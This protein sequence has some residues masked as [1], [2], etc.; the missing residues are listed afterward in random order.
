MDSIDFQLLKYLMDNG[1]VTWKEINKKLGLSSPAIAER[2]R[3]LEENGII[4]GYSAILDSKQIGLDMTAFISVTLE[5]P[6]D[7]AP[8]LEKI[9]RIKE[10]LECHHIAGD[11]D[12]LLKVRCKNTNDLD[13]V[14]TYEIKGIKGVLKTNTTIVMNTLKESVVQPIDE[15]I[16]S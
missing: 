16:D 10:V 7:R 4:K 5:K 6:D 3:R 13:R 1:R 15:S 14:I 9:Q 11:Y 2:V 12:F 8:F